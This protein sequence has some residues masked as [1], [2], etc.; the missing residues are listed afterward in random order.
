MYFVDL[1]LS[2]S[3]IIALCRSQRASKQGGRQGVTMAKRGRGPAMVDTS[4]TAYK[5]THNV[6]LAALCLS[7]NNDIRTLT[8][9]AGGLLSSK[10]TI[11]ISARS[12]NLPLQISALKHE[13]ALANGS[14]MAL[15]SL[16]DPERS[17]P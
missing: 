7:L 9:M 15:N 14:T 13:I 10:I 2:S 4:N 16:E 1:Y 11:T 17:K 5:S 3:Q 6:P 8:H 12:Q